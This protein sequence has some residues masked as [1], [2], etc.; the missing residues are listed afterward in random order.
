MPGMTMPLNDGDCARRLCA[1]GFVAQHSSPR[2]G[3]GKRAGGVGAG[4]IS[5][6]MMSRYGAAHQ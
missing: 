5:A 3:R 4:R 6:E 2:R 1:C